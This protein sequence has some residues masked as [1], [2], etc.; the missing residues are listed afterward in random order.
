LP[1]QLHSLPYASISGVHLWLDREITSEQHV[2][3]SN[4]LAQWLFRAPFVNPKDHGHYYQVIISGSQSIDHLDAREVV[5]RLLQELPSVLP[6]ARDV[7][8]LRYK[9]VT[10]PFAVF[11]IRPKV[12]ASRP[13]SLTPLT[14]L[15]L[16]G[17]YIQTGWPATMEGAVISGRMAAREVLILEGR[18][19]SID[20]G[21][22]KGRLARWLIN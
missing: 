21:L 17:D 5:S 6:L 11:S 16:A 14:R 20:P 2:A 22:P 15:T 13:S 3:F 19:L 9:V 1:E 10:D 7:K 18:T 4:M 8:V 12:H